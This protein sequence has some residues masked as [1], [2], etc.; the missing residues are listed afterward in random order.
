MNKPSSFIQGETENGP[1][2]SLNT[3]KRVVTDEES[4]ENQTIN[5]NK[6]GGGTLIAN[7]DTYIQ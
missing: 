4:Q 3:K 5:T 7:D 6:Q 1:A 2:S